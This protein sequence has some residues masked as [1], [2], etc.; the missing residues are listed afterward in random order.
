MRN[1]RQPIE[2]SCVRCRKKFEKMQAG[3]TGISSFSFPV[4][5]IQRY[6]DFDSPPKEINLCVDC[7]DKLD[8]FL[9]I[10]TEGQDYYINEE[11]NNMEDQNNE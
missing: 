4:Y 10:Y 9:Y 8:R 6:K 3:S 2:V 1:D 7:S 5:K 11:S